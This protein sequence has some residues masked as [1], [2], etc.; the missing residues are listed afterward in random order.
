V[1]FNMKLFAAVLAAGVLSSFAARSENL[2]SY[3]IVFMG[4]SITAGANLS[5]PASEAPPV[6]CAQSLSGRFNA[7]V[8]LSNQGH[9]GHT[10]LDWSPVDPSRDLPQALAA[11]RA[12]E[13]DQPGQLV[14][15]IMLGTNDS[16][17]GPVSAR[18]YRR[19]L[20]NIIDQILVNYH[21][22]FVFIHA[23]IWFAPCA[24]DHVLAL[25]QL[26]TYFP[27]IDRLVA[28]CATVHPG[29]VFTG[30][31][32][33]F[34]HFSKS[35]LTE[36]TPELRANGITYY[37]HPNRIGAAVLGKYW[38]DAIAAAL[39]LTAREAPLPAPAR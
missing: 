14:F 36:L 26:Q 13:S 37:V 32:V 24:P 15:S 3:N 28:E 23:P 19:N 9:G 25:A 30:D 33:A 2:P 22:A 31:K 38:A 10:T 27:E 1:K 16:F 29:R 6:Q 39:K 8:H 35:Y 20:R 11:A 21:N 7:D 18:D 4:D 12:L 17:K 5:D 34:A